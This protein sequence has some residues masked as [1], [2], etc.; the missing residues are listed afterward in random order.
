MQI[1]FNL[2]MYV[3]L[4]TIDTHIDCG[5]KELFKIY[6]NCGLQNNQFLRMLNAFLNNISFLLIIVIHTFT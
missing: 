6:R 3:F 4:E 5:L 1:V 2:N